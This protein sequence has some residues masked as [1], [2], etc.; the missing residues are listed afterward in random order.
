MRADPFEQMLDAQAAQAAHANARGGRIDGFL[1]RCLQASVRCSVCG[2]QG[3][4]APGS[5]RCILCEARDARLPYRTSAA[6]RRRD[7]AMEGDADRVARWLCDHE[8]RFTA[9]QV[10]AATGMHENR[11]KAIARRLRERT[12]AQVQ[13]HEP[14][15]TREP[16]RYSRP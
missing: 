12:P 3:R 5:T 9:A 8:G 15:T 7:E 4:V 1:R 16:R 13:F 2:S 10:A 11:I 6:Q 14:R